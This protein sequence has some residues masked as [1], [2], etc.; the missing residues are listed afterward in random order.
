MRLFH[1]SD[2]HLGKRLRERSLL[3]DQ[4]YILEQLLR[5]ADTER[6]DAVLICGDVYDRSTPSEEAVRL[7][8]RFLVALSGRG[9]RAAVISGNHDSAERLS[10]GGRLMA[11]SGVT[12]APVWDGQTARVRLSDEFGAVSL[13]LLPYLR[14]GQIR[15]AFPERELADLSAA[16]QA[17][18]EAM[19]PEPGE[20]NVL[21]AH[22]F[23]TGALRSDSETVFVGGEENVDAA[24]FAPFDYVALGHIHSPQSVGSETVRYCGTPLKY[25]LSEAGQQKSVTVVEL[26]AK[27]SVTLRTLPLYPL[28]ELRELRG[29]FDELLHGQ[30][31]E[32]YIYLCLTDEQ[33]QPDAMARL[34]AV[35]P[36]AMAL[37]YDN[38][39]TAQN[40]TV[41]TAEAELTQSPLELFAQL[42]RTQNNAELSCEQQTLLQRL[43]REIWEEEEV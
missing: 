2:L 16:M 35:Y 41:G 28:R 24:V 14:L 38:R 32:D 5:L 4:E 8:D 9:I 15:R 25:S 6:P 20:R 1:I 7:L 10:F 42:Y 12:L 26:G 27:G 31:S 13:W 33:E 34:Q 29:S 17:V 40:R 22:Q 39:R 21:L 19:S 23:V 36:N 3:E 30:P 37:R 43:I 18:V 11:Q